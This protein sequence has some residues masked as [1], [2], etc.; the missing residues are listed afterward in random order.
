[1]PVS[2]L[3]PDEIQ[4]ETTPFLCNIVQPAQRNITL[5]MSLCFPSPK[6]NADSSSMDITSVAQLESDISHPKEEKRP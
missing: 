5:G 2:G 1:M 3:Y 6:G 4:L